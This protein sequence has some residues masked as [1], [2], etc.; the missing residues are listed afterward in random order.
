MGKLVEACDN[1]DAMGIYRA[2]RSDMARMMESTESGRDYAA[3]SKSLIAVQERIDALGE[4]GER[5]HRARGSR[6]A[7]AQSKRLRV[8][9][10]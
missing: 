10:G 4:E 3:I 5:D 6:L 1:G 9:G 7:Q 8:V 2:L